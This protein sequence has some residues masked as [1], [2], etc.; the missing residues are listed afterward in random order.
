MKPAKY[1]YARPKSVPEAIE[2]LSAANGAAKIMA[3]GQ[4]LG[5]MLNLR[6][7]QA[8]LIVDITGIPELQTVQEEPDFVVYGA[9]ISHAAFEDRRVVDPTGGFLSSVA[10]GIAYRAV[11]N[12]GTIGG[13][14]A[15]ADPAAD[16]ITS[17]TALGAELVIAGASGT[18]KV[19]VA[20]FMNTAYSVALDEAECLVG[21]RVPRYSR[22]ARFGYFKFCRKRGEFAEAMAAIAV[23][24]ERDVQRAAIGATDAK[25]IEIADMRSFLPQ[26]DD[27]FGAAQTHVKALGI[28]ADP[29]K[30]EMHGHAF[31]RALKQVA[32]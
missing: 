30:D 7:A 28:A 24:P 20:Q 10:S 23:D 26:C 31:V 5:P 2:L 11:R 14:I 29:I 32:T 15:H 8:E 21:V 1:G 13:S 3:G 16:W 6:L 9:C 17:L 19:A 27:R 12:R 18:R 4:S 22:S 25:P